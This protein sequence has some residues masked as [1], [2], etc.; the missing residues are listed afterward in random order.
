MISNETRPSGRFFNIDLRPDI[1]LRALRRIVLVL[2]LALGGGILTAYLGLLSLPIAGVILLIC[3]LVLKG[4]AL[5][6]KMLVFLLLGYIF[7]S[8]GFATIGYFPLYIGE[9]MMGVGVLM[10]ILSLFLPGVKLNFRPFLH[11]E[12]GVLILFLI[13]QVLQTIPYFRLYQFDT[14]RDAVLYLYALFAF[15]IMLMTPEKDAQNFFDLFGRLIPFILLW[16]PIFYAISH[17]G[18]IPI[19]LP[20]APNTLFY[21]KGSDLGVHVSGIGAYMLLHLNRRFAPTWLTW[22]S[23]FLWGFNVVILSSMGRGIMVATAASAAIVVLFQPFR[24]QWYRPILVAI[25]G[26]CILLLTGQ[27]S[28][29]RINLGTH[30]TVSVEQLVANVASLFGEGDNSEGGLEGTKKW[31]LEWWDAIVDYTFHGR[32]FWTGKGYGIN[33]ADADGFQVDAVTSL[34]RSPHNGHMT[35]LGRSGVPGF[36]LWV[37][38]LAGVALR[39]VIHA[40]RYGRDP[41]KARHAI[42]LLAYLVAFCII[43]GVDVFLES[44]MGG[45]P[46]WSM[47]GFVYVYFTPEKQSQALKE[48]VPV[49]PRALPAS[50][51]AFKK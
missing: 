35:I 47:I 48:P 30:R 11:W 43:T 3:A 22:V 46:F 49:A 12:I 16:Y 1:D 8:K 19:T 33:L 7:L 21:T 17:L 44:P 20:G 25:L 45:I 42:W 51:K 41:F 5:W 13:W 31:R 23:W 29:L 15:F 28:S 2:V 34:L 6:W 10:L 50:G 9:A 14:L 24:S 38:F 18:L 36:I 37:V 39:L 40:L 4:Y 27:Y 32:Y 26:L